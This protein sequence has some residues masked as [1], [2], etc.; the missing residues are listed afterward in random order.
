MSGLFGLCTS[1]DSRM[2]A[3]SGSASK[4]E[5]LIDALAV[6]VLSAI[7]VLGGLDLCDTVGF[8]VKNPYYFKYHFWRDWFRFHL[9]RFRFV[10]DFLA[11][12]ES[13]YLP[14]LS[15]T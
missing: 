13:L 8:L 7:G 11:W 9:N 15:D 6:W 5:R 12:C 14:H 10:T 3:L 2:N 4:I 1:C